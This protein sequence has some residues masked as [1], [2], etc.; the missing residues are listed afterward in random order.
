MIFAFGM[1]LAAFG[2]LWAFL[3]VHELGPLEAI[4]RI[5]LH[6]VAWARAQKFAKNFRKLQH[7]ALLVQSRTADEVLPPAEQEA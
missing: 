4:E 5:G 3:V 6:I 7:A 2:M 1:C